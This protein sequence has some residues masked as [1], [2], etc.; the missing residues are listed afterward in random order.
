MC[1][2][3]ILPLEWD[4]IPLRRYWRKQVESQSLIPWS[5]ARDYFRKPAFQIDAT[6]EPPVI[7]PYEDSH[8]HNP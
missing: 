7:G 5:L 1:H 4:F 2:V 8:A 6:Q 3:S